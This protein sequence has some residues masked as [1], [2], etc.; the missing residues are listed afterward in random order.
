MRSSKARV[1]VSVRCVVAPA[2]GSFGEKRNPTPGE[3]TPRQAR[4][5]GVQRE[6][7]CSPKDYGTP[8]RA[9]RRTHLSTFEEVKFECQWFCW[10]ARRLQQRHY[11]LLTPRHRHASLQQR[12]QRAVHARGEHQLCLATTQRD[13]CECR[14]ARLTDAGHEPTKVVFSRESEVFFFPSQRS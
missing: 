10:P 6:Y 7:D 13:V 3:R 11:C 12:L 1:V 14:P 5:L 8:P 9:G 4:C 2:A